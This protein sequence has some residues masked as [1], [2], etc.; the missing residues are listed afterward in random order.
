MHIQSIS[1]QFVTLPSY[2]TLQVSLLPSLS[3]P[4]LS[5]PLSCCHF[6]RVPDFGKYL[7]KFLKIQLYGH[8]RKIY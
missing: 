1:L 6:L 4:F 2:L 7:V 3:L 8:F 5:S